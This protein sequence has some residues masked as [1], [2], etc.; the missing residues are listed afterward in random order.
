MD[1][2]FRFRPWLVWTA[3]VLCTGRGFANESGQP[4]I[5]G[6]Y[7][8][9][10]PRPVVVEQEQ[11]W[12]QASNLAERTPRAFVLV[13]S[14]QSMRPLYQAGTILVLHQVPYAQLKRGQTVLYRNRERKIVAHVLVARARDGWR[15]QGLNNPVHDMEPIV[16]DNLVGVVIGAYQPV[17]SRPLV[18]LAGVR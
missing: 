1:G 6:I 10:S 8:G 4:W 13:G 12:Q 18:R 7:T 14:G 2:M 3:L 9:E 17:K 11:A 15:V 5:R 16:P